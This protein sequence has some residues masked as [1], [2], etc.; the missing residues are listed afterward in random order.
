MTRKV[1]DFH[2]ISHLFLSRM[3][4]RATEAILLMELCPDLS[5]KYFA[6]LSLLLFPGVIVGMLVVRL[7]GP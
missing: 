7:F 4:D 3:Y 2:R 5:Q 6:V 1:Q